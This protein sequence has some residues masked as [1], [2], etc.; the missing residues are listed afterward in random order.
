[1]RE[2]RFYCDLCGIQITDPEQKRAVSFG[3]VEGKVVATD[4]LPRFSKHAHM[5]CIRDL[6]RSSPIPPPE[7][8]S[9]IA[10]NNG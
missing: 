4:A 7:V 5:V 10:C 3:L 2:D 8:N 9:G 6:Y 1:M